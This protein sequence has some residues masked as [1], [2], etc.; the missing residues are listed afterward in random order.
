MIRD[1]KC[2]LEVIV[3]NVEEAILAER[4]GAD[5]LELIREF[6]V[7]GLTPSPEL[8]ADVLAAVNIPV[9]VMIREQA[10]FGVENDSEITALREILTSM[11]TMRIDGVVLG[12]IEN[13]MID[14]RT[15]GKVLQGHDQS[16]VTFHRA[17]EATNNPINAIEAMHR[18]PQ[19]DKILTNGGGA[20]W[21]S[22]TWEQRI[23]R[24]Q[25]W[26]KIATPIQIL[27]GGAVDLNSLRL[28][29]E[30]ELRE[31][32]LGRAVRTP[33]TTAGKIDAAKIEQIRQFLD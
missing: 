20:D 2:T 22:G 19:I 25:R 18:F 26:Q 30:T 11:T 16:K 28:L 31:F 33:E 8:V 24:M 21:G 32:H 23:E 17:F 15:I 12:F 29:K 14:T 1:T 3:S 9:R 10:N 7:G 4:S 13:G 5:R 6:Q 27:V